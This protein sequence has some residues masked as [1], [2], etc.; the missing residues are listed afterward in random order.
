MFT[1]IP[2]DLRSDPV[3]LRFEHTVPAE[4]ESGKV[5]YYHF[6]VLD[7]SNSIV[8]HINFR[9]GDTPHV[10]NCA[11]HIGFGILPHSRGK[12]YSYFACLALA[13]FVRRHYERVIVTADPANAASNRII[14]KLGAIF[15][16]EIEVPEDDPAYENGARR[17]LR[18]EW[19]P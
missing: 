13:P 17:K 7:E 4:P 8:G 9:V 18:Y 11:G 6:R 1:D 5:A 12:S 14:E 15:I 19:A 3:S 10:M 2:D 16:N